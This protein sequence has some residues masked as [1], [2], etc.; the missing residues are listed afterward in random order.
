MERAELTQM[1]EEELDELVHDLKG[2]EAAEINNSGRDAQIAY[3]LGE[4]S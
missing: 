1:S 4:H 3:I 2:E